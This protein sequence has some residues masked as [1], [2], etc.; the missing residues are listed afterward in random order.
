MPSHIQN[1]VNII[2]EVRLNSWALLLI[3]RHVRMRTTVL[4]GSTSLPPYIMLSFRVVP[5]LKRS[6]WCQ[7][8]KH[9]CNYWW[10]Y[11][12]YA[13][14]QLFKVSSLWQYFSASIVHS[15]S[16]YTRVVY[17][18]PQCVLLSM[19]WYTSVGITDMRCSICLTATHGVTSVRTAA[20]EM[21][22]QQ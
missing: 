10:F 22:R 8:W 2:V 16:L 18:I 3:R 14:L 17:S 12:Y 7:R 4:R 15:F 1:F 13:M 20:G 11:V 9:L 6:E 5:D 19:V 21:K